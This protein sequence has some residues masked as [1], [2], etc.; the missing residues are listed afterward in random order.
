MK[1]GVGRIMATVYGGNT[2]YVVATITLHAT[3]LK[4]KLLEYQH[5]TMN[6]F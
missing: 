6:P 2:C 4:L 1:N 3:T 5:G